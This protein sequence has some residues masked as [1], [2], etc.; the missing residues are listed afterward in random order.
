MP[1]FRDKIYDAQKD[2]NTGAALVHAHMHAHSNTMVYFFHYDSLSSGTPVLKT[3]RKRFF[4]SGGE[5]LGIEQSIRL[6]VSTKLGVL[7]DVCAKKTHA[8]V[9]DYCSDVGWG[10]DVLQY[11]TSSRRVAWIHHA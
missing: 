2:E 5:S 3:T 10:P 1:A 8:I 4:Y 6:R 11:C 9:F 7:G